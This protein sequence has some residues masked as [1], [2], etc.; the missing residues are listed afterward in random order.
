MHS[1]PSKE[2]LSPPVDRPLHRVQAP[3][4]APE[5]RQRSRE[6][7]PHSRASSP[8][9]IRGSSPPRHLERMRGELQASQWLR[10][11]IRQSQGQT[12]NGTTETEEHI[13]S[14]VS[15]RYHDGMVSREEIEAAK[16][17]Y[18]LGATRSSSN[19]LVKSSVDPAQTVG[20]MREKLE[21]SQ[22]TRA[23][24]AAEMA[25]MLPQQ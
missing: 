8:G 16:K 11:Q 12:A 17:R 15:D 20:A 13:P 19:P 1:I 18:D 3:E 5:P 10:T 23:R 2:F 22:S 6:P 7:R 14:D 24:I 4:P 25:A 21:A 9:S